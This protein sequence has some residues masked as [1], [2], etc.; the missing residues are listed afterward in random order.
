MKTRREALAA[1]LAAIAMGA[2][3]PAALA[4]SHKPKARKK[5]RQ[6]NR[7]K[8][9]KKARRKV[10]RAI[11]RR[12][13]RRSFWKNVGKRRLAVVPLLL[14]VGWELVID[15][16][17]YVVRRFKFVEVESVRT[18]VVVIVDDSGVEHEHPIH[19]EDT[20]DTLFELEGSE[21]TAA[22]ADVPGVDGFIEEEVEE[23][24]EEE[25]EVEEE[26]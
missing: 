5:K 6:K 23:E 14:A 10:R 20:E 3:T 13:R 21:L 1:I 17:P 4:G 18:E 16:R 12:H 8:K 2:A 24:V 19:R 22:E 26:D 11:R 9:R 25:A 7:E 15:D